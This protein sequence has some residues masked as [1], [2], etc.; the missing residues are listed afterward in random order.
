M[1]VKPTHGDPSFCFKI[2]SKE[3]HLKKLAEIILGN[4]VDY[5]LIFG[6]DEFQNLQ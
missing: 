5:S 2:S 3:I 6:N 1:N 4:Y